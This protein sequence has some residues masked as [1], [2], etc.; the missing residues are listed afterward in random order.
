MELKINIGYNEILELIKQ[1]PKTQ[2]LQLKTDIETAIIEQ[3]KTE[4]TDFQKLLLQGPV[5]SDEQYAEYLESRKYINK[6][7]VN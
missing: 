6:W 4:T 2:I 1:L 3:E 5:M 7:R